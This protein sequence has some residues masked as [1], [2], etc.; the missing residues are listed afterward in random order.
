HL[1]HFLE[2][3]GEFRFPVA[4]AGDEVDVALICLRGP[5]RLA[6]VERD[7]GGG[8]DRVVGLQDSTDARLTGGGAGDGAMDLF[9]RLGR[10]FRYEQ[11]LREGVVLAGYALASQRLAMANSCGKSQTW[12]SVVDVPPFVV[13][14]TAASAR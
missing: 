1:V 10:V 6:G 12:E 9:H 3:L 7:A 13:A 14:T 4:V 8:A 5:A 11:Q 2:R